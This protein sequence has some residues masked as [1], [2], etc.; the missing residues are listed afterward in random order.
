MK[1]DELIE[2]EEQRRKIVRI[3]YTIIKYI[4]ISFNKKESIKGFYNGIHI[5]GNMYGRIVKE[6][7]YEEIKAEREKEKEVRE[8]N[9]GNREG[10]RTSREKGFPR[11]IMSIAE[12]LSESMDNDIEYFIGEK[13]IKISGLT[14][15]HWEDYFSNLKLQSDYKKNK[16]KTDLQEQDYRRVKR[17]IGYFKRRFDVAINRVKNKEFTVGKRFSQEELVIYKI[18]Y[19]L[20]E[21]RRY[22]DIT[23]GDKIQQAVEAFEQVEVLELSKLPEEEL[24][25]L[26]EVLEIMLEKMKTVELARLYKIIK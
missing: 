17:E 2:K 1:E 12:R 23:L 14:E 5:D 18:Y 10:F 16:N 4:W 11:T 20:R 24:G 6:Y 13:I 22:K 26:K 9:R 3:N 21:K 19:W 8:F 25:N 7:S 15:Q